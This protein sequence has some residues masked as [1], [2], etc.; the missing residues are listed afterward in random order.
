MRRGQAP[1]EPAGL[2]IFFPAFNE[3]E[4]IGAVV[5]AALEVLPR[6]SRV[7]EVIVVDDGSQ[8]GTEAV[9]RAFARENSAV[10]Y[11]RH[12]SNRGYGAAVRSGFQSARCPY[13]FYTDGDGQFSLAELPEF[14]RPLLEGEVDAV[15][16]YRRRR[17]DPPFRL[18]AGVCWNL[19]VRVVLG[20][21]VRDVDCAYKAMRSSLATSLALESDGACVSAEMLWKLNRAGCRI[22]ERPVTHRPRLRGDATGADPRVVFRAFRELLR[23]RRTASRRGRSRA[24]G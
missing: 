13:V 4:N 20:V 19:L 21:R 5:R 12:S 23:L 22:V 2:S 7:F 18:L 17:R 3:A 9:V 11:V 8:D 10:R 1:P 15:I 24:A 6:I 16:G 14:V